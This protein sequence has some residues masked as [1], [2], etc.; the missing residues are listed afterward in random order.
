MD[1]SVVELVG[2]VS[3]DP[4]MSLRQTLRM[5]AVFKGRQVKL[6]KAGKKGPAHA[7]DEVAYWLYLQEHFTKQPR[8]DATRGSRTVTLRLPRWQRLDQAAVVAFAGF[9]DKI[10]LQQTG[11]RHDD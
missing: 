9:R 6:G 11:V 2:I 5:I 7:R 10:R 4:E 3:E 8:F 1:Q